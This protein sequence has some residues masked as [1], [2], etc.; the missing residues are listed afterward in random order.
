MAALT[1]ADIQDLVATTLRD[2]GPLRFQQIAQNLQYYEV[3]SRWFKKD[4]VVFDSGYGIQR[5]LMT[6]F[7][8]TS[9]KHVGLLD[10]DQVNIGDYLTTMNVPWRHAQTSWALIYQT[11]ILMNRGKSLILNVIKPKRAAALLGL[12]EELED[13]AWGDAPG[14]TD[15][16]LPYSIQYWLVENASTGFNGGLP[17]SHTTLAGVDLTAHP[18]FKNYT[19]TYTSV[20]K[21]DLVKTMRTA[22]RKIRFKSPVTIEDYRGG[23]GDRFRIYVNE[24]TMSSL[25]DLG[26]AQ[27]ENLGRDIASMDGTIT[28]RRNPIIW[29]PKL[30]AR[31]D[32]PVYMVDHS[33]FYPVC[34]KGDYLRESEAKEAPNQH[35]CYQVFLDLSYNYLCVDRRRNA[36]LSTSA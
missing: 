1:A 12:V 2:L 9:A 13:R 15:T 28:F 19:A 23:V 33:T 32:N 25:E 10:T 34:L 14:T 20:T 4:K 22:H 30:D 3:F 29:V 7:D 17:G 27:N 36:V 6:S 5:T 11:D 18:T 26:E 31:T 35:N 8:S 21:S 24:S 16:V